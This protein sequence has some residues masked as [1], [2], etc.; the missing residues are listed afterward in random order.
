MTSVLVFSIYITNIITNAITTTVSTTVTITTTVLL[1][2][3]RLASRQLGNLQHLSGATLLHVSRHPLEGCHAKD[4]IGLV[5]PLLLQSKLDA[6][7]G[8]PVRVGLHQS[9]DV[10]TAHGIRQC[11]QPSEDLEE[12]CEDFLGRLR[13]LLPLLRD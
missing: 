9:L 5:L 1:C 2:A 7:V 3:L 12:L 10:L 8:L 11:L 6:A 4:E 13:Q